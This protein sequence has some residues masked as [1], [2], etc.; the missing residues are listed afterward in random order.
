MT[1][2]VSALMKRAR[3]LIRTNRLADAEAV[4]EQALQIC[5]SARPDLVAT[6]VTAGLLLASVLQVRS[7]P[8]A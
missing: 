4:L 7:L 8:C 1:L 2:E 6:E 3:V 5:N